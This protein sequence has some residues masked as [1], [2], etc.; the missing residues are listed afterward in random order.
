[1]AGHNLALARVTGRGSQ[2][3]LAKLMECCE[4]THTGIPNININYIC[5]ITRKM[6]P[7]MG[8]ASS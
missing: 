4:P 3:Q 8:R 7:I 2:P 6:V 5:E 1:M